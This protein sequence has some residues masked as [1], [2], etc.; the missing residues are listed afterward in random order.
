MLLF[1]KYFAY[2]FMYINVYFYVISFFFFLFLY[3]T[4]T[5]SIGIENS[6]QIYNYQ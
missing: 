6:A 2:I 3:S 5:F 4:D 1:I